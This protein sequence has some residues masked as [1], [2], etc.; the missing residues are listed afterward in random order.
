VRKSPIASSTSGLKS[1]TPKSLIKEGKKE[2][3]VPPGNE[4]SLRYRGC[5]VSTDKFA[6]PTEPVVKCNAVDMR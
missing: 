2:P 1:R 3:N 5:I 6:A 4:T